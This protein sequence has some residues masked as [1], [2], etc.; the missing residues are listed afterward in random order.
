MAPAVVAV[1]LGWSLSG[2][3]GA[4]VSDTQQVRGVMEVVGAGERQLVAMARALTGDPAV[5]L[6][7]EPSAG[8]PP[9]NQAA[10]FER[11]QQIHRSGTAIVMVEQ[12]AHR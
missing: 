8:L 11:V 1:A 9:A 6:L 2:P 3:T 4:Q 10:A 5:L 12:N 7:D